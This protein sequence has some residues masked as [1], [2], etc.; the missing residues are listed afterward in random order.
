[1]CKTLHDHRQSWGNQ[2][3]SIPSG[4]MGSASQ[5]LFCGTLNAGTRG[6]GKGLSGAEPANYTLARHITLTWHTCDNLTK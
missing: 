2:I 3:L 5:T 6:G 1:M 4:V